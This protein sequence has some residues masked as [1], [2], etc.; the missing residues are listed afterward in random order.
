M[1]TDQ[2]ILIHINE[3]DLFVNESQLR[4]NVIE[5][6]SLIAKHGKTINVQLIYETSRPAE[7]A[8]PKIVVALS[9]V[10]VLCPVANINDAHNFLG[11]IDELPQEQGE[12][13]VQTNNPLETK[14]FELNLPR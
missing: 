12:M 7:P 14:L 3:C 9:D 13:L 5:L 11:K 8:L 4:E 10:R 6:C 1:G 2:R